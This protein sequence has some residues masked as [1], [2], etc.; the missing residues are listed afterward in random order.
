MFFP[1]RRW[2]QIEASAVQHTLRQ[3]FLT[4]G[5]PQQVRFDNGKPW[6][7]TASPVP[8]ALALWLV[9]LDIR[10]VF[11]RPRQSTDN[12]VVERCHGVLNAWV[13]PQTCGDLS[14]L[15][16]RLKEYAHL[17]REIYPVQQNQSRLKQFPA[18][19]LKHRPYALEQEQ[20]DWQL[21]RV[22]DYVAEFTF[23][24]SVEKN[25]RITLMTHEYALGRAYRSQR[26][27]AQ[28][29]PA[30]QFWVVKDRYGE[31]IGH[32][33]ALQLNYLTI[34]TMTLT[35]K[36]F[37]ANLPVVSHGVHPYVV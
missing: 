35:Y 5:L 34:A 4:W 16:Q 12:A 7:N 14:E 1:L 10:P 37:K 29:D 18:L 19:M 9:G 22:L 6:G 21:Q 13:E 11:G 24:R 2:S 36:H 20:T 33:P 31:L 27:T 30:T 32:F 8:T 23:V 26:V 25:G 15:E 28:L 17:Q 3:A